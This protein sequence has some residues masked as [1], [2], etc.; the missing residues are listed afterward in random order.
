MD[1]Y[2]IP[3]R[4]R[5]ARSRSRSPA[6]NHN[7]T[8][9][10]S[11]R[12]RSRS[13]LR[14]T[15]R[16]PTYYHEPSRSPSSSSETDRRRSPTPPPLPR[17][18]VNSRNRASAAHRD[19]TPVRGTLTFDACIA[20]RGQTDRPS[21]SQDARPCIQNNTDNTI[22]GS[23]FVP[24]EPLNV[25][26]APQHGGGGERLFRGGIVPAR[27]AG[28]TEEQLERLYKGMARARAV[29]ERIEGRRGG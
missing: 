11:P 28:W 24:Y 17:A 6:R 21:T 5:A 22:D 3:K 4:S 10:R 16:R 25:A 26:R 1:G 12:R 15:A 19:F 29:V 23:A 9:T 7:R 2:R 14:H 8:R 27:L 18:R 13:P 20:S